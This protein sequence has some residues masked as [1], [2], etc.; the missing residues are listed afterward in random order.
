MRFSRVRVL[1]TEKKT[2]P[3]TK[4][5]EECGTHT[6]KSTCTFLQY[7]NC[8]E[9]VC[10]TPKAESGGQISLREIPRLLGFRGRTRVLWRGEIAVDFIF[11]YVEY[12]DFIRTRDA[13]DVKLHGLVGRLIFFLDRLV[14]SDDDQ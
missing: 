14:V 5:R 3:Y 8:K 4:K 10:R 6:S 11:R 2:A 9:M 7:F 1:L 12:D 13:V